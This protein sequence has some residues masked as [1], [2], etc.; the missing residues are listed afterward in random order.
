MSTNA[1][2]LLSRAQLKLCARDKESPADTLTKEKPF[3]IKGRKEGGQL[4]NNLAM[5]RKL[6]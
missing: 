5:N 3:L 2:G 6:F 1:A 4:C